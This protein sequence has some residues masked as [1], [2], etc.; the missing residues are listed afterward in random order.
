M[1]AGYLL[2]TNNGT[3]DDT[4]VSASSPV[5]GVTQIHE[6]KMEGDVMKMNEVPG[7]V[8]IPAGDWVILEPGGLHIMFMDLKEPLVEGTMELPDIIDMARALGGG[9]VRGEASKYPEVLADLSADQLRE[10][11]DQYIAN[12]RIQRK[13]DAPFFI[14]KMPNNFAHIGLIQLILPRAKIIDARRHPLGC[15]FS[16]FKQHF[17]R[18]QPFTY[19]LDDIGRYYR[20]YVELMAHFDAVLPGRVH[21]VIYE[22][23]VDDTESEVRR[24]LDYCGLPFDA[25]IA[26]ASRERTPGAHREFGTGSQADLQGRRRPLAP[27]RAVAWVR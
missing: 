13:T 19:G 20:D 27:F 7:G 10:L 3:A 21:R 11:G 15:C 24:L 26:C 6:M 22:T 16:G 14:D 2:I 18:G 4:L 12:T 25:A 23:L 1:G 8:V 17:A 5:A 9:R